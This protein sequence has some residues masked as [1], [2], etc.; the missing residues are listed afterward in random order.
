M[1]LGEGIVIVGQRGGVCANAHGVPSSVNNHYNVFP[2]PAEVLTQSP[3]GRVA[4]GPRAPQK[5]ELGALEEL[6]VAFRDL[7]FLTLLDDQ[8]LGMS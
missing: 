1:E 3:A 4:G 2:L 8:A 5:C 7:G 6:L